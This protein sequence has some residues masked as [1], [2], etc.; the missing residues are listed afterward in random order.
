MTAIIVVSQPK[1]DCIHVAVDAAIYRQDQTVVAF[2]NKVTSVAH[3]PGIVTCAGNAAAA[4]LFG[5]SLAK[6]FA[7]FNDMVRDAEA[8]LPG[9]TK[10]YGLPNA[11]TVIIAGISEDRGPEAYSFRTDDDVPPMNTRAELEASECYDAPFKLVKLP[12]VVMTPV[13]TD[14]QTIICSGYEGIDQTA[15][16]E[17]VIWSIRKMLHMMR[18]MKLPEGLGAIGGFA[19]ITTISGGGITQRIVER[20]PDALGA[21]IRPG[22]IDWKAWHLDNPKPA[23]ASRKASL[24]V[25][26][27]AV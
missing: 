17:D 1:H 5:W 2:G 12:G 22:P 11:A 3:W 4:P 26:G 6:Q 7:T 25:V 14:N 18:H 9:L 13:I 16:P 10:S 20:W 27:A 19:E 21:A 8:E 15:D 23:A 24:H